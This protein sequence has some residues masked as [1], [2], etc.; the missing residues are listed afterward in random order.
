MHIIETK[1]KKQP[2][3]SKHDF[4]FIYSGVRLFTA[5]RVDELCP[6]IKDEHSQL[7]LNSLLFPPN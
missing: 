4:V 1:I 6:C 2:P 3:R 7:L 5:F